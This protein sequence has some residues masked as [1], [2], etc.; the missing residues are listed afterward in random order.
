[1]RNFLLSV[2][3]TLG[4]F[5]NSQNTKGDV[6]F[7]AAVVHTIDINFTQTGYWDSLVANYITDV[8][9]KCNIVVDGSTL[10]TSGVKFKGNSSYN[11]PSVKKSFKLDFNE[12]VNGQDYDGLKKL[13]LN[14]GFKDPTF[15]REKI[16][17]D[18]LIRA[19][20]PAPRCTY[21]RVNLNGTFWGLYVVVEEIDKDFLD[22]EF[23]DDKGNLFK[24]D[25]SGDLKWLG[26]SVNTYTTKY[27]LKTNETAN[28]WTDL[29]YLIDK[30]NNSPVGFQDS[31]NKILQVTPFLKAWAAS[32]MFANLDSYIGSGHNYYVYHDSI[33]NKFN[34]I[35]W[36]VNEAFGNFTQGMSSTQIETLS[37]NYTGGGA[38]NRPLCNKIIANPTLYASYVNEVCYLT[39][40][41][42]LQSYWFPKIDSLKTKIMSDV[43]VDPNK[44]FTNTQFDT[45]IDTMITVVGNPGNPNIAGLKSF[46]NRR[47]ASLVTQMLSNSCNVGL[48]ED[49]VNVNSLIVEPNPTNGKF[50]VNTGSSMAKVV[51]YDVLG[52]EID[53][54]L[55]R[56]LSNS[57]MQFSFE[58]LPKGLYFCKA[59]PEVIRIIHQ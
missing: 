5:A 25:P 49:R 6:F 58:K 33:T 3:L 34:W 18:F 54:E 36:D 14:N 44:F 21:A 56:T 26:S 46:F 50:W 51:F 53:I 38:N 2:F 11:N 45:N 23:S 29:V 8:Y 40:Y 30:I 4:L 57:E 55:I 16:M 42:F 32:N 27:E 15:M 1:M 13:N 59:G 28:N 12:Y 39:G 41:H 48:K 47:R 35:T 52:K 31:L 24:G 43:Y 22:D 9:M 7:G 17:L 10:T 20:I 19:G 37:I